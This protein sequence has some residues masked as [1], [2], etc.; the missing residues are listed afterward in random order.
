VVRYQRANLYYSGHPVDDHEW[1][2]DLRL[3]GSSNRARWQGGAYWAVSHSLEH[4]GLSTDARG[5]APGEI[6]PPVYN[7]TT[8]PL[9]LLPYFQV[10][11]HEKFLAVFGSLSYNVTPALEASAELRWSEQQTSIPEWGASAIWVMVTPRFTLAYRLPWSAQVYASAARGARAGGFSNSVAPWLQEIRPES[12]WTYELGAKLTDGTRPVQATVA[13]FL[14]DWSNMELFQPSPDPTDF[15]FVKRNLGSARVTG[16]ELSFDARPTR[17]SEL[18]ASYAHTDARFSPRT[19]DLSAAETCTPEICHMVPAPQPGVLVPD[20][21]GNRLP[22][23]P[24]DAGSVSVVLHG[25]ISAALRWNL[26][27]G[28][29]V[30]GRE[31]ARTDN[32]NWLQ[33]RHLPNARFAVAGT[34]WEAA[35]W[36]RYLNHQHHLETAAWNSNTNDF[37]VDRANGASWGLSLLYHTP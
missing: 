15:E 7:P 29:D 27:A 34:R 2:E 16:L 4:E 31:Y 9:S 5:L 3:T 14:A 25:N 20:V 35:I 22:G 23:A 10:S 18:H 36:G 17:W 12:N 1:S 24:I 33:A 11:Q 30:I 37:N 32:L 8:T 28:I 13:V 6:M 19:I 21:G 26:D